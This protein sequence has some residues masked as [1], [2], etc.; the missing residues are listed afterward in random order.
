[1]RAFLWTK[2]AG[3]QNLGV[4]PGGT[5]SQAFAINDSQE[6]VGS[7]TSSA[8][9][10]AFVWT[11]QTGIVD[12]NHA[13]SMTLGIAFVEAHSINSK[14]EILAMGKVSDAMGS[15]DHQLCA[16]TLPS[17]FVLTPEGSR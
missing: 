9:N 15:L 3:M 14:G 4:L 10:R 8:G 12:L 1:M 7:S 13:S 17:S 11:R 6:V 2:G 5:S 16:P